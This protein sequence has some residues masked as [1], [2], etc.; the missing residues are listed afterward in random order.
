MPLHTK[1][2]AY[3]LQMLSKKHTI[4]KLRI[5]KNITYYDS[6]LLINIKKRKWKKRILKKSIAKKASKIR[7]EVG[8]EKDKGSTMD[9]L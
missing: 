2:Y 5:S 4:Q 8:R 6:L 3:K 1:N 9:V 7:I